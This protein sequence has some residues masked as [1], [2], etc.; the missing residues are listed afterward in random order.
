MKKLTILVS[1]ICCLSCKS[2]HSQHKPDP[3]ALRLTNEAFF[4]GN[5]S[6]Y[7]HRTDSTL[8]LKKAMNLINKAI[9]IDSNYYFAYRESGFSN[10]VRASG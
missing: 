6:L 8:I 5:D 4:L 7:V 2:S 1:V 10:Q 9:Q 3:E